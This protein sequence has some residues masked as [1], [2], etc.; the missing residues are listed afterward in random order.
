MESGLV[1]G[2]LDGRGDMVRVFG[3]LGGV[4]RPWNEWQWDESW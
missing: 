3:R 1:H 4:K 2:V